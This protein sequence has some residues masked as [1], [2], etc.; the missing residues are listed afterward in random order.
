MMKISAFI[1][2][3]AMLLSQ[4]ARAQPQD[5]SGKTKQDS[6]ASE[7]QNRFDY[8]AKCRV[9]T[10]MLPAIW[11]DNQRQHKYAEKIY[12]YWI[13]QSDTLGNKLDL[14]PKALEFQYL[15]IEIKPDID[16]INDCIKNTKG[17]KK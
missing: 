11:N 16:F 3:S 9:H 15:L 1:F 7:L 10:Q 14:S 8:A 6:K 13:K 4:A 2:F 17:I 5:Q 12:S